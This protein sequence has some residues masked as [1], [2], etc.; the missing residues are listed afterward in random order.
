MTSILKFDPR[1]FDYDAYR[2]DLDS[3]LPLDSLGHFASEYSGPVVFISRKKVRDNVVRFK[4]AM[5][6]IRPH[7]A[8]KAN[9]NKEVLKEL[10]KTGALFEV[11][12]IAEIDAM[13]DLNVEMAS[14]LYSNPVKSIPSIHHAAKAGL[15][16]FS[17]DSP[18]EVRKIASIKR[19]AKLYL[20]IEVSNQDALWPLTEKFGAN[21][22]DVGS[23]IHAAKDLGME[24]A[25]VTFHVGSQCT[26][27]SSWV[28]AIKLGTKTLNELTVNGF[29]PE[30]LNIGGG[31][32]V[33]IIGSEPS[34]EEIGRSINHAI[35]CL[36]P[37][38]QVLAEPGRFLVGSAGCLVTQVVGLATRSGS[39][40]IYLDTG[41]Y[42]GLME[43]MTDFSMPFISRRSGK[44]QLFN[45]AGPTCDSIDV[46]G[47]KWLPEDTQAQDLIY[48]PNTGAY[49]TSCSTSFNGFPPATARMVL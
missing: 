24:I 27:P 26:N 7:F 3:M 32:P 8:V 9:P 2:K 36:P 40:W 44:I 41:I 45:L 5:P 35:R 37:N 33:Q 11:A 25:G 42:G 30:V 39:R 20:R 21:S 17:I 16:W 6:S 19:E 12:S 15:V 13:M 10:L 43:L 18:E 14:V 46:M 38:I 1:I 31:F 48:V 49:S 23:I 28:N 29:K 22:R 4:S 34:I 47:K